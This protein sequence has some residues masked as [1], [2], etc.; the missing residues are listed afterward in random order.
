MSSGRGS[1]RS[2]TVLIIVAGISALLMSVT[3]VYLINMRS[4]MEESEVVMREAQARI[5]L[6]AALNYLQEASRMGWDLPAT[7]EHEE[8]FGW[9]DVR[10]GSAGPKD[11][12]GNPLY[13]VGS[14]I[15]PDIGGKAGRFPLYAMERPP[16]ALKTTFTYNPAPMNPALA[17]KDLVNYKNAD[18]QPVATLWD[19]FEQGR[20]TPRQESFGRSWFRIYRDRNSGST[21]VEPATFTIT[22]GAGATNGYRTYAEAVTAGDAA[23]FNFDP[24]YFGL[25]RTQ[26]RML[27]FRTEW[28]AAVGGSGMGVRVQNGLW[29]LPEI[30]QDSYKNIYG[31]GVDQHWWVNRNPVGSFLYIERLAQEPNDW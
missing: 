6:I 13:T 9:A 20:K 5:V 22:C 2:G 15:F 10:D 8:A 14:G 31:A 19:D 28:T 25:L 26:E 3:V 1:P 12:K 30:N 24:A 23:L 7:P 27:W 16:Y 4:D 11:R 18:P 17:W 21:L 29:N